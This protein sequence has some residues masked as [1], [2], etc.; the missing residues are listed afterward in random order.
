M[1]A[2]VA[3][4]DRRPQWIGILSGGAS[5]GWIAGPILGGLLYD[6]WGPS[7]ALLDAIVMR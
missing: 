1:V 2:D 3:P 5:I 4:A 7:A 6:R